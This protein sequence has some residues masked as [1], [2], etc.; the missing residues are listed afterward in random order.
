MSAP[1]SLLFFSSR[2]FMHALTSSLLLARLRA[3]GCG[4]R[5]ELL[6]VELPAGGPTGYSVRGRLVLGK[7]EVPSRIPV[8]TPVH[9]DGDAVRALSPEHSLVL[10]DVRLSPRELEP[11]VVSEHCTHWA[12]LIH[13][14]VNCH[15]R[16]SRNHHRRE[17]AARSRLTELEQGPRGVHGHI[18]R[19][20]QAA[21]A[22]A[23][24][25]SHCEAT[26]T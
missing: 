5:A 24:V 1:L 2:K 12:L 11:F 9:P 13:G 15:H 10:V 21:P 22:L 18:S 4:E 8:Q 7:A 20:M 26:R 17:A 16:G 3:T 6:P 25:V 19:C 14:G 23:R